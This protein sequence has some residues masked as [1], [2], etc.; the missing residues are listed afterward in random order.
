MVSK[1]FIP[2]L[3]FCI[4]AVVAYYGYY[5]FKYRK[6]PKV[7]VMAAWGVGAYFLFN[8]FSN[9]LLLVFVQVLGKDM[10]EVLSK[11]YSPLLMV[12]QSGLEAISLVFISW[13]IIKQMKNSNAFVNDESATMTGYIMGAGSLFTPFLPSSL[14][15][16]FV[17]GV[18]NVSVLI[19]NP[20][21]TGIAGVS[22]EDFAKI[23]DLYLSLPNGYFISMLLNATVVALIITLVFK[24]LYAH[25]DSGTI[26]EKIIAGLFYLVLVGLGIAITYMITNVP[27]QIMVRLIILGALVY[28][29]RR[30]DS[31]ILK[32]K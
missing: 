11:N 12:I 22:A 8:A 1:L 17:Q 5:M 24:Y 15:M 7:F 21:G 19:S 30:F 16:V 6:T 25:F 27:V 3:I 28:I 13:F 29:Y 20:T 10:L 31:L 14:L 32:R 9:A 26:K 23:K 2:E 18:I 4:V